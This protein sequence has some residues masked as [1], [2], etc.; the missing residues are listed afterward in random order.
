MV[1]SKEH[2]RRL[3][4][5]V[6]QYTANAA[7]GAGALNVLFGSGETAGEKVVEAATGLPA[8]FDVPVTWKFAYANREPLS[9]AVN[10]AREQLPPA[11]VMETQLEQA[12]ETLEGLAT[13]ETQIE[14]ARSYVT[15][16]TFLGSI[17][18]AWDNREGIGTAVREAYNAFPSLDSL[19]E[20]THMAQGA[21]KAAY[22]MLHSIDFNPL[23]Q[24]AL[25]MVDNTAPDEAGITGALMAT[26]LGVG[27]AVGKTANQL[28]ARRGVPG[29]VTKYIMNK[30]ARANREVVA[31]NFRELYGDD[32]A[33]AALQYAE[34][35]RERE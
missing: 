31:D 11:D 33:D 32:V 2:G 9:E 21:S 19:Q 15:S 20:L 7:G 29:F 12:R 27:I 13:A 24:G 3:L 25:N 35:Q 26:S 30:G 23:Y 28:W 6:L 5:H 18:Q 34:R 8:A 1:D 4:G 17:R 22:A 14:Q 10:Y 16:D